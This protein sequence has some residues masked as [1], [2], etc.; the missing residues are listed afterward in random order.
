MAFKRALW[1]SGLTYRQTCPKCHA[2]VEYT[3][4]SLDFRPWYADG[5]VYC[6]R[7]QNPL[8]HNEAY[9]VN[10]DGTPVYASPVQVNQPAP[11]APVAPVAPAAPAAPTAACPDCGTAYTPGVAHFC[12]N[13][14][15]KLD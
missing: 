7:C 4:H 13:C 8:R 5:F 9:A 1:H 12:A 15:K 10:P 6:P 14:G 11:G 2:G 3:D